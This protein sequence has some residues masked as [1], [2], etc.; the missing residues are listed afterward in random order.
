MFEKITRNI[1]DLVGENH[2]VPA[3]M[4]EALK[5][6]LSSPFYGFFIISWIIVNWDF[7]YAAIFVSGDNIYHKTNLLKNEYLLQNVLPA[8]YVS[9]EY[10]LTFIIYP[11]ILTLIVFWPMQYVTRFFLIRHIENKKNEERI[12]NQA[13]K[14]RAET[15]KA[16]T[17]VYEAEIEQAKREK[18]AAE[19]S[20]ELGWKKEYEQFKNHPLFDKFQKIID[21]VYSNNG[22]TYV[23]EYD[24]EIQEW[25]SFS[26]PQDVLV[27]ADVNDLITKSNTGN[28]SFT[29]KGKS[30][31]RY[32]T[33]EHIG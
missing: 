33:N 22:R 8:H 27:F 13:L 26:V 7:I 17:A 4:H 15:I 18:E 28:I 25:Y 23:N 24:S 3:S 5:D 19:I 21:S 29:Q 12:K 2:E 14:V 10:W 20:P 6:R 9:L 16:E 32:Y 11:L 1:K 31:V 30:F